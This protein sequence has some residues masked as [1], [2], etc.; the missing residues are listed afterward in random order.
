MNSKFKNLFSKYIFKSDYCLDSYESNSPL[1][2]SPLTMSHH[3]TQFL[4]TAS[5][6]SSQLFTSLALFLYLRHFVWLEAVICLGRCSISY[7]I[8]HVG[9][10]GF[11]S[12]SIAFCVFL[13][14]FLP[15]SSFYFKTDRLSPFLADAIYLSLSPQ[16]FVHVPSSHSVI[17]AR[18]GGP[19]FFSPP[20]RFS[21][22]SSRDFSVY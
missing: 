17:T 19:Q 2:S 18:S 5:F 7:S 15:P 12:V 16:H 21:S 8:L 13:F 1:H 10:R 4:R 20:L 22:R 11:S 9:P 3:E 6:C 14:L